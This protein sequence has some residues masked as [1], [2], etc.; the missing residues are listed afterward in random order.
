[1]QKVID[2]IDNLKIMKTLR[3]WDLAVNWLLDMTEGGD[4]DPQYDSDDSDEEVLEACREWRQQLQSY[5]TIDRYHHCF[6]SDFLKYCTF[7]K[8]DNG[9]NVEIWFDF[10]GATMLFDEEGLLH[11]D[12]DYALRDY[13]VE[14]DLRIYARHGQYLDD[15]PA[16]QDWYGKK[17]WVYTGP[18]RDYDLH[19]L[20]KPHE[21][22]CPPSIPFSE[23]K[24]TDFHRLN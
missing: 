5:S 4:L 16:V 2:P 17:A 18:V 20:D 10:F 12:T 19:N 8:I 7:Y 3:S 6:S 14:H 21:A 23:I 13:G 9:Y 15:I 1:M 11:S 24:P 22:V